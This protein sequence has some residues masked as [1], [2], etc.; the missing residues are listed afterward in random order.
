MKDISRFG[1]VWTRLQAGGMSLV[2]VL[3][4]WLGTT[5][6]AYSQTF[7]NLQDEVRIWPTNNSTLLTDQRF[8]LRVETTFPAES[9][10]EPTLTSLRINGVDFTNTFR[11]GINQQLQLPGGEIEIGKPSNAALFGQTLRNYSFETPGTYEVEA[12]VN[13]DG[14]NVVARNSYKVQRFQRSGEVSRIIVHVGDGMGVPLRTAARIMEYG[15]KDGQ[16]ADYLQIEKMPELGLMSTHSLDSII[17]DS[18]NTAAAWASG[19]K[20]INN[21]MNAVPDNTPGNPLD[22]PRVETLPQYMKRKFNWGIG[23]ATTA[24]TTD[25]TP[26]AFGT[27]II[28]RGRALE[29]AQ[30][31]L[32]LFDDNFTLPATGY[33]SWEELSQP[34]DVILGP[35]ARDYIPA[36]RIA[37][38]R[39]TVSRARSGGD[40]QDLSVVAENL[41]Y[42]VVKNLNEMNS[43]PN[44]RPILGLFLGDFRPGS[45]LGA[46]N[47]P[48]ELDLLISRG[49][50]TIE[51]RGAN[52]LDPPIP[53]EFATIPTLKEMEQKA[54]AVLDQVHPEGWIL[55]VESSQS[56]K[57]AHP[58]DTDRTIY[59]VLALDQAVGAAREYAR[60]SGNTLLIVTSDHAQG[61]TVGG[62]V[63]SVGI[64]EGRVDLRDAMRSFGGAGFTTYVDADRNGFPDDATPSSKLAIGVSARPVLRTDFLTDDFNRAPVAGNDGTEVNPQRDPDGLLLTAD[65]QRSTT[66]AN[67]TA[68]DVAIAAEG[69]GS[70][71]FNGTIDNIQVFQ[72]MAAAIS[73][74]RDRNNLA[75]L[76]TEVRPAPQPPTRPVRPARPERPVRPVR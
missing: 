32:D 9:G 40:D 13:I 55:L 72:R 63:D 52:E 4:C 29:I 71:L 64:R 45:A 5:V 74:V 75:Q 33:Q 18:A 35:G 48:S 42:S 17:P 7:N 68:D 39:D 57:L 16:P 59:E 62:T 11:E 38:F 67:H 69:P 51:G 25:A 30:T 3:S 20:T 44:N 21:A 26:G 70:T 61:Q 22:N 24:Y 54:I 65:L 47:I 2:L 50:A 14:R 27:N 53:P 31:Y 43:A 58:L 23:L 60:R 66:V 8:D 15:V 12:R 41:G 36:S 6:P 19:V 10:Q 56:D 46:L 76:L 28:A 1:S 49:R 73:G 34:V 37:E